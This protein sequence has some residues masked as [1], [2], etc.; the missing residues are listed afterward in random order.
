[1]AVRA[2]LN[3]L[4]EADEHLRGEYKETTLNGKTVY[5]LDLIN[6]DEHPHV[7]AMRT[8][9]Q[10][11]KDEKAAA[12]TQLNELKAKYQDV[13]EDFDVDNY[14]RLLEEEEARKADPDNKDVEKR[15]ADA[16]ARANQ[17]NQ[18]TRDR[19]R[20][21]DLQKI[22]DLEKVVSS[23]DDAIKRL[24]VTDG[25]RSIA[26]QIGVKPGLIDAWIAQNERNVEVKEEN[27]E[28][29]AQMKADFGNADP[30]EYFSTTWSQSDAAK[31][32]LV[33]PKSD[34][35]RNNSRGTGTGEANPF[36]Q[37]GWS[38]T[39]QGKLMQT[40]RVRAEALAKAA[41]FKSLDHAVKA[42]TPIAA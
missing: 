4:D 41:G 36:S 22:K 28:Y 1:M 26:T 23:K 5:V 11:L 39:A 8:T 9:I 6:A 2:I 18:A 40:N 20:N 10:S 7:R 32:F 24:L 34:D 33:P 25:L 30:E 35:E 21:K 29:K 13:P 15:I 3:A 14:T 17:Q 19:E 42:P 16:V 27:G 31:D 12:L 38:K 37:K